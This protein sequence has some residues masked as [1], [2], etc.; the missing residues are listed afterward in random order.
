MKSTKDG[1]TNPF[2]SNMVASSE[3]VI[4]EEST[5]LPE[6]VKH[7]QF[8]SHPEH[9]DHDVPNTVLEPI[10]EA[11]ELGSK[12]VEEVVEESKDQIPVGREPSSIALAVAQRH[13]AKKAFHIDHEELSKVGIDSKQ[14]P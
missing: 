12:V 4:H 3:Q 7:H 13:F 14:A 9:E 8:S 2:E 5:H 10:R 11:E 6:E 1:E